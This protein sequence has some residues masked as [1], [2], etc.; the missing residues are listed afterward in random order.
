[1]IILSFFLVMMKF[2]DDGNCKILSKTPEYEPETAGQA[3]CRGN[4]LATCMAQACYS[5]SQYSTTEE[6][7]KNLF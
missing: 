4:H 6:K 2:C 7:E 3:V 1:M 5:T